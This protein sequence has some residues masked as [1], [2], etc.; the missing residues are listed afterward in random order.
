[1][2]RLLRAV[3]R[4]EVDGGGLVDRSAWPQPAR[5]WASWLNCTA[6][7]SAIICTST[8]NN[9]QLGRVLVRRGCLLRALLV[10]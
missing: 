5:S 9:S 7:R 3:A 1:M 8:S 2:K 6:R 4:R 10:A